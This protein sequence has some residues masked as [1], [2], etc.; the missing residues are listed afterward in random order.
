MIEC[1][2]LHDAVLAGRWRIVEMGVRGNN[3]LELLEPAHLTFKGPAD[4]E[5][6]SGALKGFLN[7]RY[8]A[9]DGAACAGLSWQGYDDNDLA[10]GRGWVMIGIAD[11][12]VGHFFIHKTDHSGF[13]C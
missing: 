4:G 10:Y 2:G 11:R 6:A 1:W 9:R 12:L 5:I 13:V 3:V 8:G 7:V